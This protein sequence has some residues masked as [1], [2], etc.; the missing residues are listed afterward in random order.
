MRQ[1]YKKYFYSVIRRRRFRHAAAAAAKYTLFP[2]SMR[3]ARPFLGPFHGTIFIRNRCNAK[4]KHC[5]LWEEEVS[6][7]LPTA[8]LRR[9]L[10]DFR[11]IGA[12]GVGFTG[13]EPLLR[14]D[15][16]P[17]VEYASKSGFVTH[18]TTN[19]WVL[20]RHVAEDLINAGLDAINISL[21]SASAE[22]HDALRGRPGLF[23]R[24]M[25]AIDAAA[26]AKRKLNSAFTIT[27]ISVLSPDNFGEVEELIRLVL[28]MPADFISFIPLHDMKGLPGAIEKGK[29]APICNEENAAMAREAIAK[30][31]EYKKKKPERFDNSA[32]YIG[33]FDR[34]FRGAPLGRPCRAGH[35]TFAADDAGAIFPCYPYALASKPVA[36]TDEI[37]LA[38]LWRSRQYAEIRKKISSCN[39]CLWNCPWELNLLY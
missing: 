31:L 30:I 10:D 25:A 33:L 28:G 18:L 39:A 32:R 7:V 17:L 34:H 20:T 37:S 16:I 8:G 15:M 29:S 2:A 38:D 6:N 26:G 36:S 9:M 19:G 23:E 21:D 5:N 1:S 24:V 3:R 14:E 4:C 11:A 35:V 27:V 12:S 22:K 13:G